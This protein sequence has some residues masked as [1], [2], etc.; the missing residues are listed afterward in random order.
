M[1]RLLICRVVE[2]VLDGLLTEQFVY[3][4]PEAGAD[5]PN[6]VDPGQVKIG[7]LLT[8]LGGLRPDRRKDEGGYRDQGAEQGQQGETAATGR[9]M[10]RSRKRTRGSRRK[11]MPAAKAMGS[12]MTRTDSATMSRT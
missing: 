7:K 11:T 9:G 4:E 1:H 8:N 3:V 10:R 12:H 5:I 6:P 2:P